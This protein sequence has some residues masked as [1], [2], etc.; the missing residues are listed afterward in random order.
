MIRVHH[1]ADMK[2]E[3]TARTTASGRHDSVIAGEESELFGV[4]TAGPHVIDDSTN[5][6]VPELASFSRL[7]VSSPTC[8][9][10]TPSPRQDVNGLHDGPTDDETAGSRARAPRGVR[11]SASHRDP[12]RPT[13]GNLRARAI[14]SSTWA[15][16]FQSLVA[17]RT[18]AVA[19]PSPPCWL[20]TW[21]RGPL[22]APQR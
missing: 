7:M 1:T 9:E 2:G 13:A 8:G 14:D 20:S 6:S 11:H 5:A 17:D 18:S 22:L 12:C 15:D 21:C 10:G 3:I 4:G 19:R 16:G